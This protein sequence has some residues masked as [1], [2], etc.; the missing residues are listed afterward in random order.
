MHSLNNHQ[1]QGV[2]SLWLL[3]GLA[4][5]VSPIDDN[6]PH[7]HPFIQLTVGLQSEFTVGFDDE[8]ATTRSVFINSN[9]TH[10]LDSKAGFCA[11]FLI[12]PELEAAKHL[13]PNVIGSNDICFPEIKLIKDFDYEFVSLLNG[14]LTAETVENLAHALINRFTTDVPIRSTK[15]KYIEKILTLLR[16]LPADRIGVKELSAE[17]GL[18][19]SRLIH[20]FKEQVGMPVRR[21]ILWLRL[22]KAVKHIINGASFTDAAHFAGFSDSAHLSRTFRKM[23][24]QK[25]LDIFSTYKTS[26]HL[27]IKTSLE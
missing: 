24:G 8:V 22:Q 25:M 3:N 9:K 4:V 1:E 26:K 10:Q 11:V 21:Y 17:V 2:L 19:E 27:L 5:F 15:N 6:S 23:F 14:N 7:Q 16:D 18:S 20:L 13:D 12:D